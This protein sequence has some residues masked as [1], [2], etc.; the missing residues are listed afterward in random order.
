MIDASVRVAQSEDKWEVALIGRN[1]TNEFYW[2]RSTDNPTGSA[3][4]TKLAD[5]TAV[6]GRGR[7]MWIRVG[8]KY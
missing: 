3:N 8:F 5:T 2:T 4:P 7:E 6:P 1:L